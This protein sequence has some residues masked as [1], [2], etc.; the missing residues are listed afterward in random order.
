VGRSWNLGGEC[1]SRQ[2]ARE[3]GRVQ[4]EKGARKIVRGD[5]IES[6]TGGDLSGP[7]SWTSTDSKKKKKKFWV[8][9]GK[10]LSLWTRGT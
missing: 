5:E 9:R 7:G 6:K 3:E 8:R 1:V 10:K 2:M 4:G